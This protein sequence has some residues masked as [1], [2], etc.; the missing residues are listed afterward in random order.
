ML[1]PG[2]NPLSKR[3]AS[4]SKYDW[5]QSWAAALVGGSIADLDQARG[6][7]PLDDL[8]RLREPGALAL[9]QR[10]EQRPGELVAAAIEQ[11]PLGTAGGGEPNRPHAPVGRVRPD[12]DEPVLLERAHQAP[13]IAGVEVQPHAQGAHLGALVG[14]LPQHP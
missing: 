7:Q 4:S 12:D 10:G 9:A 5:M 13:E 6:E 14:H 3:A 11:L 1:R 2:S 8:H